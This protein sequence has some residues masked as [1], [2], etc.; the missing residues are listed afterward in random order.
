VDIG[1]PL[2]GDSVQNNLG[3]ETMNRPAMDGIN[4]TSMKALVYQGPGCRAWEDRT[5][6]TIMQA[7]DAIVRIT[8]TT[9]CGTD[10]HFLK[11]D[12]PTVTSGRIL[13]HEGVGLLQE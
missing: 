9:I 6:P 4:A 3:G 13:G 2:F 1:P 11:G 12:L 8:T 10:L 5:K 7:T